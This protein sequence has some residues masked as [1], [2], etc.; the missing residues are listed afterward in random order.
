MRVE[1]QQKIRVPYEEYLVIIT[2]ITF[3]QFVRSKLDPR[4]EVT[5]VRRETV[6]D[7]FFR[8]AIWSTKLGSKA[9]MFFKVPELMVEDR[10]VLDLKR[11]RFTWE[12]IPN[13][14]SERFKSQG[15]GTLEP[16]PDGLVWRIAGDVTLK[17]ALVGRRF[18]KRSAELIKK[19]AELTAKAMERYY[20]EV[21][22]PAQKGTPT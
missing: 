2:S 20:R 6:G 8:T 11:G 4:V 9:R 22:L 10:Q 5:T 14:F 15:T 12:Y 16:A 13:V 1:V 21:H 7:Q 17:V 3:A 18:E 19:G